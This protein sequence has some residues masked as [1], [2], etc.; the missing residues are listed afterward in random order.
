[1]SRL[2]DETRWSSPSPSTAVLSW[3][4][5]CRSRSAGAL[6]R[7]M[8]CLDFSKSN[9]QECRR[10]MWNSVASQRTAGLG[11]GSGVSTNE[12]VGVAELE[13]L[14][15]GNEAVDTARVMFLLMQQ[16]LFVDGHSQSQGR[17]GGWAAEVITSTIT[18]MYRV[19][20]HMYIRCSGRWVV[21]LAPSCCHPRDSPASR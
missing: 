14:Q 1:M 5:Y 6:G 15:G 20:E 4:R 11:E 17:L 7:P 13:R 2:P 10:S 21:A 3:Y 18:Y 8:R 9:N 16:H 12:W 19:P